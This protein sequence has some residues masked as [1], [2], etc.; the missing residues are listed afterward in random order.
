MFDRKRVKWY[1][2]PSHGPTAADKAFP[3][4]L[5]NPTGWF[6]I[7]F[8]DEVRPGS[9]ITRRFVDQDVVLY[10]TRTGLLRA[11]DP[12]CPHLGAHLGVGGR[13]EGEDLIC[14]FHGFAFGPDG[15][16]V[17]SGYGKRPPKAQVRHLEIREANDIIFVWYDEEGSGPT[18]EVP[19]ADLQEYSSLVYIAAEL[20]THP[21]EIAENS[22]DQ[23][24][25]PVMHK[26][27]VLGYHP[28]TFEDHVASARFKMR[29]PIPHLPWLRMISHYDGTLYG[30]GC[31]TG[32]MAL[33]ALGLMMHAWVLPTVVGPWRIQLRFA[34][35][36]RLSPP[37]WLPSRLGKA[38]ATAASRVLCNFGLRSTAA[39]FVLADDSPIWHTKQYQP[40]PRIAD[41]DGPIMAYRR[42]ASQFYSTR[43]LVESPLAPTHSPPPGSGGSQSP[44]AVG[45]QQ[46]D[47]ST[48]A[49]A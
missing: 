37:S 25:F 12:Y 42:W 35:C 24:H 7:G 43:H 11:I 32:T 3:P 1:T 47:P 4:A 38:A 33:P 41:G 29:I 44:L 34:A 9:V 14:P 2:E 5:P 27:Q 20:P 13:V 18:W 36:L 17:R 48:S 49:Q 10:R 45:E 30:L 31:A 21:Q 26:T 16:C 8:A 19:I 39:S 15:A 40:A 6:C 22:V 23:G 28:Y 46:R